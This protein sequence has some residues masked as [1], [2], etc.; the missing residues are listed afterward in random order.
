MPQD[1]PYILVMG[2][3]GNLESY[4]GV[5]LDTF[6]INTYVGNLDADKIS[7]NLF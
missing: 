5:H 2:E 3:M 7:M 4:I 6:F 1:S